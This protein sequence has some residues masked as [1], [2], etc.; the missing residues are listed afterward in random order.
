MDWPHRKNIDIA[1]LVNKRVT[2]LIGSEVPEALRPL[3][4]LSVSM[5]RRT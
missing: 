4:V 1:D 5:G 2:I 3:E